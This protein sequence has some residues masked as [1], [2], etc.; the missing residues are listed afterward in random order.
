MIQ[1]Q[2]I[3]RVADNSGAKEIMCIRVLGGSGRKELVSSDLLLGSL[4]IRNLL[5]FYHLHLKFYKIGRW[6]CC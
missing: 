6:L 5:K 4:E 1:Q 2:T 3:L